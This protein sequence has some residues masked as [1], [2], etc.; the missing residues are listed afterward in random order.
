MKTIENKYLKWYD[1]IISRR[2]KTP[3]S[4]GERH[5]IIPRSL[6]G[7]DDE[8]NIVVLTIREHFICHRLLCKFV[9]GELAKQKCARALLAMGT[10]HDGRRLLT[11]RQ[12]A[13]ARS[14]YAKSRKGVPL[15]QEHRD[16]IGR[17]LKGKNTGPDNPMYGRRG[18][19]HHSYGKP[20]PMTGKKLSEEAL[21]KLRGR[22]KSPE[23]LEKHRA[24]R[25]TSSSKKKMSEKRWGE[26]RVVEHSK[27]MSG[28]GNYNA[29]TWRVENLETGEVIN[30]TSL[31]DF[32]NENDLQYTYATT[33]NG[34]PYKGWII[35]GIR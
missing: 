29:K 2:L 35:T 7:L 31:K 4:T 10:L 30:P 16:A 28:S 8:S 3:V 21:S 9:I 34:K 25:H 14:V 23:T 5:H 18:P 13:I 33:R 12:V 11:S 20:G 6:G 22:Q 32:C 19:D 15:S 26:D 24:L 17:A 1:N 27:A